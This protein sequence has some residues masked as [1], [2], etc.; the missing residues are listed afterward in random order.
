MKQQPDELFRNKL[1]AYSKPVPESA[2][3]RIE[4]GMVRKPYPFY[5]LAIAASLLLISV[6]IYIFWPSPLSEQT[7][8]AQQNK[9]K[10]NKVIEQGDERVK[11]EPVRK[12]GAGKSSAETTD[13][14]QTQKLVE[15][16]NRKR[17]APVEPEVTTEVEQK[18]NGQ[19]P[20]DMFGPVII[21][22]EIIAEEKI[23]SIDT[24]ITE[25]KNLFIVYTAED[26]KEYLS[27]RIP[28]EATTGEETAST[29]KKVLRTARNLKS[30]QD[31]VGDLRQMKNEILALNFKSDKGRGQKK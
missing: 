1:R 5:R 26:T 19:T 11:E 23:D 14:G 3:D 6:C 9:I 12:E 2:W 30:N 13:I 10:P 16:I 7:T 4:A 29:F 18:T 15:P 28:E 8:I 20:E 27:K 21:N 25:S 24:G 22:T 31:P 17:V